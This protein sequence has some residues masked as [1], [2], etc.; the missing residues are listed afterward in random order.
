MCPAGTGG[1]LG[2]PN[3]LIRAT[4]WEGM[5][6]WPTRRTAGRAPG[7]TSA[8][9]GHN[10]AA[11][12]LLPTSRLEAF[13]DGVFA[14]SITLLVLE[15]HV[16]N[17]HEALVRALGHEWPRY[18]GYLVSFAFIG[19]VWIAHSNMTR[20]IKAADPTLMRLNLT[21]LLFVSFLPFTTAIVA[22]HLFAT[23][24]PLADDT[25]LQPGSPA[26]RVAVVLFGLNLTLAAFMV[27][28]VIRYAARTPGM[29]ADDVAE[30][31]LQAFAR[32]R[33]AAALFQ[34][35]ATVLGAF[36]PVIAIIFYLAVSLVFIVEP[37]RRVR[38]RARASSGRDESA[39]PSGPAPGP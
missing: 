1:G 36:L 17:G 35:G 39:E 29:A 38:I 7:G 11:E 9:P 21:L 13:S 34:G 25:V 32:E 24:L 19:G 23:V 20:F 3:P 10:G 26:E 14:I 5:V 30:E 18:L 22:T 12:R 15:L 37:L 27:Y 33:R 16:P 28:R 8:F 6:R 31:E 2:R 4:G